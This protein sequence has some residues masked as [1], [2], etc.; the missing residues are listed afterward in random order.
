[1]GYLVGFDK[2]STERDI[3]ATNPD[4]LAVAEAR[5]NEGQQLEKGLKLLCIESLAEMWGSVQNLLLTYQFPELR[6]LKLGKLRLAIP[7]PLLVSMAAMAQTNIL[8][9]AEMWEIFKYNNSSF[10]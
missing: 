5:R 1:M 9:K 7:L 3:V 6:K 4:S 2:C 8:N 10:L